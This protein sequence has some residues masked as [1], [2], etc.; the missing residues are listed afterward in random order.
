MRVKATTCEG[1]SPCGKLATSAETSDSSASLAPLTTSVV[2]TLLGEVLTTRAPLPS[3]T[4]RVLGL[5][6]RVQGLGLEF[7]V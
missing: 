2:G 6:F 4:F 5:W 1:E 3:Y 7:R